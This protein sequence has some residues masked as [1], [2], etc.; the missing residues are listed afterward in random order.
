MAATHEDDRRAIK[1][2]KLDGLKPNL[3]TCDVITGDL[4]TTT[5]RKLCARA[6]NKVF[7]ACEMAQRLNSTTVSRR[8]KLRAATVAIV[9]TAISDNQWCRA[10]VAVSNK[11]RTALMQGTFGP[12]RKLRCIEILSA[13]YYDPTKLDSFF[14]SVYRTFTQCRRLLRKNT[15]RATRFVA[16]FFNANRHAHRANGPVNGLDQA[17]QLIKA[18]IHM[19]S[20]EMRAE[21]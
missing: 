5:R 17:A 16:D 18:T 11:L 14:A 2:I 13:L 15:E 4:V 8:A 6:N 10:S 7:K 12:G 20:G 9:P 1:N 3:K 21:T 19:V